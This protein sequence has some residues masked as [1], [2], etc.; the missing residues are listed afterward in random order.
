MLINIRHDALK[1]GLKD[2]NGQWR[3]IVTLFA[4]IA[5]G[6]DRLKL[7]RLRIEYAPR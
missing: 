2:G 3:Q 7:E 6:C 4:V 1:D 5:D